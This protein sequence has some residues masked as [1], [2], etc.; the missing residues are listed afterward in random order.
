MENFGAWESFW[1]VPLGA[2][3]LCLNGNPKKEHYYS[4]KNQVMYK[5]IY[6]YIY[7]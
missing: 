7:I 1:G 3:L 4:F 5:I 2:Y 6:I